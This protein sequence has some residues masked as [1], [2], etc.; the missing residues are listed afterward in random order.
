MNSDIAQTIMDHPSWKQW[1]KQSQP[2]LLSINDLVA[3]ALY[4]G[5]NEVS[6]ISDNEG[7][8]CRLIG[9]TFRINKIAKYPYI[10]IL[11]AIKDLQK[12][13]YMIELNKFI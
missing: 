12:E 9:N 11:Y 3:F 5:I 7:S 13:L 6:F 10:A 8:R 2:T 1:G 4:A